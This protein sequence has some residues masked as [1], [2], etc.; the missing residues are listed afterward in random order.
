MTYLSPLEGMKS[1]YCA[2]LSSPVLNGPVIK[3][4]LS[5]KVCWF[6]DLCTWISVEKSLLYQ[7]DLKYKKGRDVEQAVSVVTLGKS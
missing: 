6:I 4:Q 3:L 2:L 7:N 1:L 5:F